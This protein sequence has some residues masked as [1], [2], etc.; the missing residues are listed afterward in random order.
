MFQHDVIIFSNSSKFGY[1]YTARFLAENTHFIFY[2]QQKRIRASIF[3]ADIVS[4]KMD[5]FGR[6]ILYLKWSLLHKYYCR[7]VFS[8]DYNLRE[9]ASG[10]KFSLLYS[11]YNTLNDFGRNRYSTYSVV[12]SSNSIKIHYHSVDLS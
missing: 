2:L 10:R 5:L 3:P 6:N 1:V 11:C 4:V 7:S 9:D 12:R 8:N